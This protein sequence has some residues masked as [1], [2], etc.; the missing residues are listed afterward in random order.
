LYTGL[1]GL[2]GAWTFDEGQGDTAFDLSNHGNDGQLVYTDKPGPTWTAGRIG[3]AL[4]FDGVDDQV[5]IDSVASLED[6]TDHSHTFAAWVNPDSAPPNTTANDSSHSILVRQRTGLYYDHDQR[7]RALIRLQDSSEIAVS[8][9]VISPGSW[10]HVGMVVDDVNKRLHLYIDGQEVAGSPTAYSGA[11]ADLGDAPY[12]I[13]TSDP[14]TER[15]EYRFSGKIDEARIFSRTLGA[16]EVERLY[17]L[18]PAEPVS[19]HN[20]THP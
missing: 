3:G 8:S 12:Y 2:V 14:L 11:L 16:A 15:Y 1:T 5:T 18:F 7:Y 17:A 6:L 4:Q 10:R 19:I 20:I 9:G 13:G